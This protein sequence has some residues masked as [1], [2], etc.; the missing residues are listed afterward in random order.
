MMKGSSFE[1]KNGY[2]QNHDFAQLIFS[3]SIDNILNDKL[4]EHQMKKIPL[5]FQSERHY[6]GSF[7]YPL[8]EETRTELASSM[9]MMHRAP[10]AKISSFTNAKGKEK[11][12]YDVTV[13][14]WRNTERPKE[15]YQTLP[16][17]L[18]IL[19]HREPGS[20][21]DL[22]SV[23][24]KCVFL[25][26]NYT[27]DDASGTPV[28]FKVT[29][30][31]NIELHDEMFVVFLMNI[32]TQKR[33]WSSLHNHANLDIIKEIL[34]PNSVVK[35]KCNMCSLRCNSSLQR[36]DQS[37]V[38]KLNESQKAA[39]MASIGKVECCHKSS[40]EQIW[41][42]PGT[43]KTMTV[44]VMLFIFLQMKCRTLT[45]AP[46]NVA[47][48]AVA[49]RV[50]SLI[51]ESSKTITASGDSFCSTGDLLLFGNKERLKVGTEI[52]EIY[53]DHR[54]E[55]LT[56]CFGSLTGWKHCMKSMIDLL[57][58]CVSQYHVYVDNEKF[59]E[60]QLRKEKEKEKKSESETS[61]V[62]VD[63][64]KFKE[65][66]LRKENKSQTN[67]NM[68]VKSFMEFMRE[69]FNSCLL[70]LKRCIIT[71]C[72]HI[73]RSFIKQE[74]FQSMVLL[75]DKLS[76]LK[77][78]LS[79]KNLV[80]QELERLFV[81]KPMEHD[82]VKS[83]HMS[84]SINSVRIIS[85]S[86]L[87]TLQTSLGGLKLPSHDPSNPSAYRD[88]MTRFC[89]ER[90]SLIFC[91]TS[92]S[93]KLQKFK[94]EPLKL[95]V[96][97]EAAQ[98]KESE[99]I[100]PLQILGMKHAILIGDEC[101]LP[102]TVK[103]NVS[104]EC[105]LG[106]SLFERLS[107]LG[108]SKHLLNVQYRMHPTISSFPNRKFYQ[109]KILDAENVTC[110]SYGR[111]YL[112][113]PMFGSYS[114]INIVGGREE[115]DDVGSKRNMVEVSIV[116]KIVQKLYEEWQQSK[117]KVSIGVVSP[118]AAQ[119]V[120]IEEK[121]R[122]KYEKRDGFSVNVKSIDG[123][124]GGEEDIIILSTVRSNSHGNVGFTSSHQRT[125]VALTRARHCLWIL[126]NERTLA[127]SDSIWQDL[128]NDARNRRCLFDAAA[129]K[130]FK[131]IIIDVKKEVKP[132]NHTVEGR[133]KENRIEKNKGS[134]IPNTFACNEQQRSNKNT[135]DAKIDVKGKGKMSEMNKDNSSLSTLTTVLVDRQHNVRETTTLL[136]ANND[137]KP[138]PPPFEF[139]TRT[140]TL[141]WVKGGS[142]LGLATGLLFL[143]I[144]IWG[145]I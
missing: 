60:E 117:R 126:G 111:Q 71:F 7:V 28:Q 135:Q 141:E 50:L 110:K 121:L 128:V 72:T 70:P 134:N 65:K 51:K 21:S 49:S 136:R 88:A 90:A 8:L 108:H 41:G 96:I 132:L 124:Q 13:R 19:T 22:Q 99:A 54:I 95:L 123:F 31:Q 89:Y 119:V 64:K 139:D 47:I 42:P 81:S 101:Q 107:L 120:S 67:K 40:V 79:Q 38:S 17:D 142:I 115:G 68:K 6:F 100:I 23:G 32:T 112:S 46:T 75:L 20:V 15:S 144:R 145:N 63:N 130:C 39:I 78:L 122:Y 86:L 55:R 33:I 57:E 69:R 114:F 76:S 74:N 80:S 116:V 62:Y 53:L 104:S 59:K 77:S 93:F 25:L 43:G 103:S 10:F 94:M 87:K 24:S 91:T 58:D 3:W 131:E 37:L 129:D 133:S 102:A 73:P 109:N 66:Q 14:N 16:N 118:Y 140:E 113:G 97:D 125:N 34:Y 26:V 106:R 35:E 44:S 45:C 85:L 29:A 30:S 27:E 1:K 36:F 92:T 56:Q 98:M 18:L 5:T 137:M 4:Y 12:M 82:F 127:R 2:A 84:S 83:G 48:V 9:N 138:K 105:G 61:N 11:M 52:E 143:G